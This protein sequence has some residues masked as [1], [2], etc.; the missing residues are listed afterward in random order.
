MKTIVSCVQ[1][2]IADTLLQTNSAALRQLP[3]LQ[4]LPDRMQM[5][6]T[7]HSQLHA[8]AETSYP[9]HDAYED[10]E[11]WASLEQDSS[12]PQD[13]QQQQSFVNHTA[14]SK[15]SEHSDYQQQQQQKR[16][17]SE[18]T[19]AAD[20]S[21]TSDTADTGTSLFHERQQIRREL[22][23]AVE[24]Q[25]AQ[26][27]DSAAQQARTHLQMRPLAEADQQHFAGNGKS[28]LLHTLTSEHASTCRSSLGLWRLC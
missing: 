11:A 26:I 10:E 25:L 19:A 28:P 18:D 3:W 2:A 12:P 15:A 17:P 16:S 20:N 4:E 27:R 9:R 6:Q 5:H 13:V 1:A 8:A 22:Q 24:H 7:R 21:G 23:D 14:T